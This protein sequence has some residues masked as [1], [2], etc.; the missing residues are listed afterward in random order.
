[1]MEEPVR[2]ALPVEENDGNEQGDDNVIAID[3]AQVLLMAWDNDNIMMDTL[4]ESR[5]LFDMC[6]M[7]YTCKSIL[8]GVNDSCT[9]I[10]QQC[11]ETP[12]QCMFQGFD[13]RRTPLHELCLRNGC[14]HA[15]SA[16]LRA[17]PP[18][19]LA[20]DAHGNTPLHL[21]FL[22]RGNNNM[23]TYC[24]Q[25]E[26]AIVQALLQH[27]TQVLLAATNADG[28]TP[29]HLF[30]AAEPMFKSRAV[31]ET[32]LVHSSAPQNSTAA[33]R[34]N[35]QQVPL[36]VL[37]KQ[38]CARTRVEICQVL[39][40]AFPQARHLTDA[41]FL[42][43]LHYAAHQKNCEL[44]C[45][46]VQQQQQHHVDTRAVTSHAGPL[47]QTPLLL[48]CQQKPQLQHLPA[49]QALIQAAPET[50]SMTD[51]RGTSPLHALVQNSQPCLEAISLVLKHGK[52]VASL[53]DATR[54]YTALH[55]ACE[56][57]VDFT[58]ISTLIS[59]WPKA[60]AVKSQRGDLPL[61][62]ACSAN[63]CR[64]TVQLLVDTYPHALV[65][66]NAYGYTPLHTVCRAHCPRLFI[67]QILVKA[68]PSCVTMRSNGGKTP[69][70]LACSSGA[71][72][73]VLKL[74]LEASNRN[75]NNN[76]KKNTM[77]DDTLVRKNT[78]MTIKIG[79]TPLHE[80]CFRGA[81]HDRIE[82]LAQSNPEWIMARNNAGYTP[83]QVLCKSGRLD[84][85]V[86]WTFC[87]ICGPRVFSVVD[88]TGH[89]PLHSAS[90]DGTDF[91]AIQ[92]LIQAYPEA[93]HLKT[94]Y[95]DTP[96]HL[97]ILRRASVRVV[98]LIAQASAERRPCSFFEQ[99]TSGQTPIG[100][101]MDAF[102]SA[103]QGRRGACCVEQAHDASRQ[104][105]QNDA[106]HILAM[107]VKVL[108]Y[109]P[110][111][112]EEESN[113]VRACVCLHRQDVRLDPA[114]IRRAIALFPEHV[115]MA[116]SEGNY[117][118]HIEASIPVEKM[119]LLD[120]TMT[121][122]CGG[123]CHS[124]S[125]ILE[126]LIEAHPAALCVRNSADEFPLSLMIR[127]GRTWSK[128]LAL[129]LRTFPS[130]LQWYHGGIH[131]GLYPWILER[132]SKHCG[133]DTLYQLLLTQPTIV[134]RRHS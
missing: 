55:Y 118:L 31:L 86:V 68:R 8:S 110:C 65:W 116:D 59:A 70:H 61:H 121:G 72:V 53:T 4:S 103:C 67:V 87:R 76:N 97:S 81:G 92:S 40:Q 33:A 120:S 106:F 89:A 17:H 25:Q 117:P 5:L 84:E 6:K 83:L 105:D 122:C 15:I 29:L 125:G 126:T 50:I 90:R 30:C 64:D 130:A 75:N 107:L 49:L 43:P 18:A 79:N 39:L 63:A 131:D 34:N 98:R 124:R 95:G 99:N 73:K 3:E 111:A 113:L 23:S 44:V 119:T 1:M 102:Q 32:L 129:A 28:N 10:V 80:A 100:I 35:L 127:S 26:L 85:R 48:L 109:G 56:F 41:A 13:T 51:S 9:R 71:H 38:P 114:F 22:S 54:G 62:I 134:A 108:Y 46:L 16:I 93:L 66:K 52:T 36:H 82:T 42:T 96:L 112:N 45:F 91:D 133:A 77:H 47:R 74:L 58:I 24:S 27:E 57:Q 104:V 132:V 78:I 128:A 88:D 2:V 37:S 60:A 20:R 11:R 69:M 123:K 12:R 101:A 7:G 115:Q 14:I 21:L 94:V 19:A